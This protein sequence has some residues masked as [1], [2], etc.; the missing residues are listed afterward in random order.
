MRESTNQLQQKIS[1]LTSESELNSTR[2]REKEA[3]I[4]CKI[5]KLE[6]N[7]QTIV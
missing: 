5:Q 2:L 1:E 7:H 4:E 3:E 6:A